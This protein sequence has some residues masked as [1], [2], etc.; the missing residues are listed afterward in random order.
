MLSRGGLPSPL[1]SL[2]AVAYRRDVES[3][4]QYRS[5]RP[6]HD[7][8]NGLRV[9]ALA[10]GVLGALFIWVFSVTSVWVVIAGAV[11]GGSYGFM[12]QRRKSRL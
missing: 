12:S 7:A 3:G 9:G 10:G 1:L 5:G 2:A 4:P 8:I 6:P 11:I